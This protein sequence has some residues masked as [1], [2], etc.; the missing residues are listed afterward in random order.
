M[1]KRNRNCWND[2]FA[3]SS[4][5]NLWEDTKPVGKGFHDKLF[6]EGLADE[7]LEDERE[8][9]EEEVDEYDEMEKEIY[10]DMD[11]D[12]DDGGEEEADEEDKEELDEAAFSRQHYNLISGILQK[13]MKDGKA[14]EVIESLATELADVFAKD[15]PSFARD[16]FLQASGVMTEGE[17]CDKEDGEGEMEEG[18]A[19]DV[20]KNQILKYKKSGM[21]V[22]EFIEKLGSSEDAD[23][24]GQ[25]I[26][27]L[28]KEGKL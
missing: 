27:E 20:V 21:S 28:Q 8:K 6:N 19:L 12:E 13:H 7:E 25:A 22:D 1:G 9:T 5:S 2:D 14:K 17:A 10:G 4:L 3:I 18:S 26:V 11:E 15:N 24:I 16:R 23:L